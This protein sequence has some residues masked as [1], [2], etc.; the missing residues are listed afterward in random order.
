MFFKDQCTLKYAFNA[1]GGTKS[2]E[3]CMG[4]V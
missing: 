1:M 3:K 2:F 4:H